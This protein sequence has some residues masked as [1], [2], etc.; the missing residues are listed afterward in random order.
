MRP[1]HGVL[2]TQRDAL[3]AR[4]AREVRIFER[5]SERIILLV[6]RSSE[7]ALG[8]PSQRV[9]N[10]LTLSSKAS[11]FITFPWR[12][13]LLGE[14]R[15]RLSL[16]LACCALGACVGTQ[17]APVAAPSE[18][19]ASAMTEIR[20]ERAASNAAIA[21]RDAKGSVANMLEG[22]RGT[23][24][25]SLSHRSRDSVH[26]ALVRQYSDTAMLGYVRTPTVIQV[27]TTGPAA[28]EYGRWVGRRRRPDG[29]QEL[30]GTYFATWH[31]TREG[32]RI[33][34]EAFVALE[35]KGST[36]CPTT[37]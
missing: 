9:R 25:Q 21:R 37:Y 20:A 11:P 14:G 26:A 3:G 33:N 34:A 31:H 17:P 10:S 36:S 16:L 8:T 18:S 6:K 4:L 1:L 15:M 7:V 2:E 28:A 5:A 32:W 27:S 35:C 30:A 13:T 24:A 23:W 19:S 12:N 29:V 22:Y